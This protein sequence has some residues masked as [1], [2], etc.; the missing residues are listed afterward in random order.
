VP[1]TNTNQVTVVATADLG[2]LGPKEGVP[3]V[4][5]WHPPPPPPPLIER[6]ADATLELVLS[7]ALLL[8]LFL[9]RPNRCAQAWAIWLPVAVSMVGIAGT[10]CLLM[11]GDKDTIHVFCALVLGTAGTWLLAPLL[12]SRRRWVGFFKTFPVLAG[13]SVL[14]FV[15]RLLGE[16]GGGFV[17]ARAIFAAGLVVAAFVVALALALSGWCLRG[18]F[19]RFRLLLWL[20]FW[21]WAVWTAQALPV[22]VA[23]SGQV[24]WWEMLG[25]LVKAAGVTLALLLPL[26]LWSFFRPFYGERLVGLLGVRPESNP[27]ESGP[28]QSSSQNFSS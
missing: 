22:V 23:S 2:G 12:M 11:D 15:P 18:R 8:P 26:L 19:S 16:R 28:T 20:A 5:V 7:A 25:G 10:L 13:L 3:V 1:F 9:Y 24:D 4:C 6:I 27:A 14:T 21:L 17:D